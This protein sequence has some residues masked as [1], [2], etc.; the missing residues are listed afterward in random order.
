MI[1]DNQ[2]GYPDQHRYITIVVPWLLPDALGSDLLL[3]LTP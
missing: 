2:L 3:L 1:K